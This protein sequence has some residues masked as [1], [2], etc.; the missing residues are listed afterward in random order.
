MGAS[1]SSWA[2]LVLAEVTFPSPGAVWG[3]CVGPVAPTSTAGSG[4]GEGWSLH[5]QMFSTEGR[6]VRASFE[7]KG[8][9]CS[10]RWRRIVAEGNLVLRL[11]EAMQGEPPFFS[12]IEGLPSTQCF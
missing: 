7:R 6:A 10:R 4:E 2:A 5:R 9:N 3:C 1:N 8:K 11:S 12:G